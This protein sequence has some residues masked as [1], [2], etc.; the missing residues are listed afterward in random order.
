MKYKDAIVQRFDELYKYKKVSIPKVSFRAA[1]S[2]ST[3]Y[4]MRKPERREVSSD[5]VKKM[6]D[7]LGISVYDFYDDD[8]FKDLE[9]EINESENN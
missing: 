8:I 7:G 9:L 1:V 6:C 4:S 5:T 2:S 3:F